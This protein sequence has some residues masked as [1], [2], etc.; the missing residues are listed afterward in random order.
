MKIV[1]RLPTY[2]YVHLNP[3]EVDYGL[4]LSFIEIFKLFDDLMKKKKKNAFYFLSVC[5]LWWPLKEQR[6]MLA[7]KKKNYNKN[8][9]RGTVILFCDKVTVNVLWEAMS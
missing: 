6:S 4:Y 8:K 7:Y 9:V 5:L 1:N 2:F 3:E